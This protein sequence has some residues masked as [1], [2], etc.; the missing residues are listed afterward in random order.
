MDK[1]GRYT[2]S[3]LEAIDDLLNKAIWYHERTLQTLACIPGHLF[4]A[5]WQK[6]VTYHENS[7]VAIG[8]IKLIAG[9]TKM[10]NHG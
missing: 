2:E 9:E 6:Q 4:S 3:D 8:H 1:F 7:L 5:D 10:Y